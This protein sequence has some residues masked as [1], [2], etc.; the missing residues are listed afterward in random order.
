MISNLIEDEG[1]DVLMI[2]ETVLK[3]SDR[4]YT[5]YSNEMVSRQKE[6]SAL[7]GS[8]VLIRNNIA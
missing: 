1:I 3:D 2:Q 6:D 7:R 8:A 4:L 5:N